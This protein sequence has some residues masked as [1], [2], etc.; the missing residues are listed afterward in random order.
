M[1]KRVG[2]TELNYFFSKKRDWIEFEREDQLFFH[3]FPSLILFQGYEY[4]QI[5]SCKYMDYTTLYGMNQEESQ[6]GRWTKSWTMNKT[7]YAYK[8][9][10]NNDDDER[11]NSRSYW[12]GGTKR[13]EKIYSTQWWGW[14]RQW[15]WSF[16]IILWMWSGR[17]PVVMEN[18]T[19]IEE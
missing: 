10:R 15:S 4:N 1:I 16:F 11:N 8:T 5:K 19:E 7:V 2:E 13:I 3:P 18:N 6:H 12:V 9:N 14:E 17:I